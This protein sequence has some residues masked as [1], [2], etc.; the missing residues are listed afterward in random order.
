MANPQKEN[1]FTAISNEIM[2]ALAKMRIPGE[3]R[4]ML[5][6]IIRKT[7]GYGKKEDQIATSQFMQFTGLPNFSIHRARARLLLAKIITVSKKANSQVLTYSFV[8]DYDK[9]VTIRKNVQCAKKCSTIRKNATHYKQK[10]AQTVTNNAIHNIKK[11]TITKERYPFLE[12]VLFKNT[13]ESYLQGR[14]VKATDHA[15]ELILKDLHKYSKE[16]AIAML[17]Q[18]IKQGWRG[19]WEL[20][21]NHLQE[22]VIRGRRGL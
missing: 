22:N 2:E 3:A 11:E 20:K 15:K 9:W 6:V 21:E 4:Q 16:T 13:F 10:S 5:D 7:Y 8:K 12:D 14:K 19:I 18:S 1:G 17:E